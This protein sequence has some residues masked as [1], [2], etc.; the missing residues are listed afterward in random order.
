M[1]SW[2][3]LQLLFFCTASRIRIIP[4]L[5][6][7]GQISYAEA[8]NLWRSAQDGKGV[9]E[10]E[11]KTLQHTLAHMKYTPKASGEIATGLQL[12]C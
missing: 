2:L 7:S 11:R 5:R 10:T 12:L 8:Y 6:I 3:L 9:T 4:R 1:A